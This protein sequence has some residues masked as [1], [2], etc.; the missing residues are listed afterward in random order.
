[1]NNL[2]AILKLADEELGSIVRNG[3]F[4]SRE[5]IE[6]ACYLVKMAEKIYCIWNME[7]GEYPE[8][9]YAYG[10]MR[11]PGKRDSRGR[12]ARTGY[13]MRDGYSGHGDFAE[14][15][16]SLMRESPDERTRQTIQRMLDQMG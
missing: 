13:G 5:E 12:Y 7:D 9:G 16:R 2:D 10:D 6:S 8:R 1:M 3:K 4:R 14:D 15:L 11:Y